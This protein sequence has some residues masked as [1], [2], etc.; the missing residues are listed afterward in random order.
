VVKKK[1]NSEENQDVTVTEVDSITK[2][3]ELSQK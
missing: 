1:K 3:N 2:M